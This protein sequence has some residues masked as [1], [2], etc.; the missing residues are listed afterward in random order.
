[1]TAHPEAVLARELG[2]CYTTLGLITDL[3]AG[4]RAGEGVTQDE[5]FRVFRQ[6]VTILQRLV[7]EVVASLPARQACS[8][9]EPD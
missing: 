1:M 3:D 4:I 7:T 6:N 2:I 5:I 9:C 8:V